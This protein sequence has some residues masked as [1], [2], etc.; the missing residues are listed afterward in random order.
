MWRRL[1]PPRT[2]EFFVPELSFLCIGFIWFYIG[3]VSNEFFSWSTWI[4]VHFVRFH[5][6]S[7]RLAQRSTRKHRKLSIALFYPILVSSVCQQSFVVQKQCVSKP[8]CKLSHLEKMLAHSVQGQVGLDARGRRTLDWKTNVCLLT[9]TIAWAFPF[10]PCAP[11]NVSQTTRSL[12]E[13]RGLVVQPPNLAF[14]T[15][16]KGY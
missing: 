1:A 16:G 15:F 12:Q 5:W 11:K 2:K 3:Y 10:W 7:Q 14:P 13:M 6:Q 4:S 9:L 8:V